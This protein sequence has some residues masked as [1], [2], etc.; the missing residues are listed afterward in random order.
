M[1][2]AFRYQFSRSHYFQ[3]RANFTRGAVAEVNSGVVDGMTESLPH[4]S[5][6]VF[7]KRELDSQVA[8][9]ASIGSI[10]RTQPFPVPVKIGVFDRSL[11]QTQAAHECG[12]VCPAD[13]VAK[14]VGGFVVADD[15]HQR[16]QVL[17]SG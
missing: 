15:D 3:Q 11:L 10:E 4:L 16:E 1:A 9:S 5:V 8:R 14:Q 17:D 12:D 13:F 2:R 7:A 6:G